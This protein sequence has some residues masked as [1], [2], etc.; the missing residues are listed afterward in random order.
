MQG[1]FKIKICSCTSLDYVKSSYING[2]V[3]SNKKQ[4]KL[5]LLEK[6]RH[7]LNPLQEY[8]PFIFNHVILSL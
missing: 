1:F 5:P 6:Q 8:W 4:R 3:A 2:E 7:V